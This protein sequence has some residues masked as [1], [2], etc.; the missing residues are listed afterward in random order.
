M[1]DLAK[2]AI[3]VLVAELQRMVDKDGAHLP[4][5][6]EFFRNALIRALLDIKREDAKANRILVEAYVKPFF[7]RMDTTK[8]TFAKVRPLIKTGKWFEALQAYRAHM[9]SLPKVTKRKGWGS[10]VRMEEIDELSRMFPL[11]DAYFDG[12]LSG[13]VPY[14]YQYSAYSLVDNRRDGASYTT[15]LEKLP[16]DEVM[17]VFNKEL[18]K[19]TEARPE[20]EA[21]QALGNDPISVRQWHRLKIIKMTPD[22]KRQEAYLHGDWFIFDCRDEKML[23]WSLITDENGY[24]H[25]FGG[26]HNTPNQDNYIPGS[27]ER[28]GIAHGA[29]RPA[30]MYWVSKKPNDITPFEFV[31]QKDN[32]RTVSGTLNYMNVARSRDARIFLYGRGD[33]WTWILHRYDAG[34]RQWTRIK[35]SARAMM[36]TAKKR[37]PGW[38][39]NLGNTKPYSGPADGLVTAWQPGGYNFCRTWPHL[40]G[41][42]I[43]GVSFDP[44]GRMHICLALMG[45]IDDAEVTHRPVYAYSDDNGDTFRSAD[46]KRLTLPL[47]HNPIPGH[48]ADRTLEP[49]RSHFEVWVSLVK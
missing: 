34:R 33:A 22:G 2:A 31:G 24:I 35:G 20:R 12:Y 25:L 21:K 9:K 11:G 26:Q 46:G 40:I 10:Y 3:P 1:G 13:G 14:L 7:K 49:A 5:V 42:D 43:R 4:K 6:E 48:N 47:T 18:K 38:V 8:P 15:L 32:P 41:H 29:K 45:V 36:G 19:H 39:A 44:S 23:G 27:W 17:Q 16:F 37:N 30:A 28:L